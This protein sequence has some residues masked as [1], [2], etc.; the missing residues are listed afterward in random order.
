[1]AIDVQV[2]RGTE[3]NNIQVSINRQ[4]PGS[5][6]IQVS[7]NKT[8][9]KSNI[10]LDLNIRKTLDGNLMIL[11]HKDIDI[12]V[13]PKKSKVIAFA[14]EIMGDHVYDSQD[15]FFRFLTNRGVIDRESI[16]GGNIYS[17]MEAS[18][19]ASEQYN[20]VENVVMSIGKF[21]EE[22]RPYYEYERAM[23]DE[24][25]KRLAE[26]SPEESTEFDPDRHGDK[27]GSMTR[28]RVGLTAVYRM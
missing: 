8:L 27:K 7:V 18:I 1:M 4:D 22:E 2:D 14:K 5:K 13:F 26:P 10:Q 11:D 19:P 24:M 20:M 28:A 12:V 9:P 16:Q 6:N 17:S 25:E 15:R 23:E 3:N 21:I